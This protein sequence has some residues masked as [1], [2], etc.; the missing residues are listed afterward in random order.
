MSS[1]GGHW[2]WGLLTIA[3]LA[4]YIL[5]TGYVAVRG[6]LDIKTMLRT[7]AEKAGQE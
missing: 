7:L 2:F 5:I 1:T 4:W 6:A 3:A